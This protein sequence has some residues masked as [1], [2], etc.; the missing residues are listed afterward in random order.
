MNDNSRTT[1]SK[2]NIINGLANQVILTLLTFIS[3]T[4]FI[5]ILGTSILGINGLYTNILTILSLSE[6]GISSVALYSL[7]KPL[8]END[9]KKVNKLVNF[10]DGFYKKIS[11]FIFIVGLIFIP[12]LKF[13]VKNDMSSFELISYYLFFLLNVSLS[14]MCISKQLLIN[15]SQKIY[16]IKNYTTILTILKTIIQI[17]L[18]SIAKNYYIYLTIEC[19]YTITLNLTLLIKANNLFPY[20]NKKEKLEK[21]EK[22]NIFSKVKDLFVYKISVVIVN[23]TDNIFISSIVGTLYVG[24]YSNYCLIITAISNF[25]N[26]II[27][28]ITASIGNFNA[29]GSNES[30]LS[31]FYVF[32][33]AFQWIIS[34]ISVELIFLTNDFINIWI[35]KEYILDIKTM[36]III[37]NFY[38]SNII[39]PIWV[40]RETLGLFNKVK[41]VMSATAIINIIL[42][43]ILGN[44]WGLFGILLATLISRI[45]TTVWY[46]PIILLKKTLNG[47]VLKY[48]ISQIKNTILL[49]VISTIIYLVIK[50][51]LVTGIFTWIIKGLIIFIIFNLIYFALYFR[52]KEFKYLKE[53]LLYKKS[54]NQL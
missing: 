25:V 34:F 53:K 27:N 14:Y 45:L 29:K 15:A 13:I 2:R 20:L 38:L 3:R 46:E 5:K 47:K 21:N 6:L 12:F 49:V 36:L 42:S 16:I 31:L 44:M 35:G 10:Y 48:Y 22:K 39:T 51:I 24:L 28:S 17:I 9:T 37:L 52:T 11:L 1:R 26:I 40:H 30:K 18:L 23:S 8:A 54:E 7:Y 32:L 50:R 4:I 43:F 33:F 41:Y 19:L